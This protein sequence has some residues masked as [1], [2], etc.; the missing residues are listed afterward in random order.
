MVCAVRCASDTARAATSVDFAAW[1]AIS[2][3]EAASSSTELAA[4]VTFCEAALTRL[5]GGARFR[6]HRVGGAVERGR[7][8]FQL[9]R[10]AAQIAERLLDRALGTPRW[11]WRRF[12]CAAPSRAR[13]W[14]GPTVRRS[15]SIMLSRNT[16]TVRAMAPISSGRAGGGNFRRRVAAG[17]PLHGAGQAVERAG[18]AAA[19]QPAEAEADQHGRDADA[20]DDG[21]GPLLRG[22]ERRRGGM[23]RILSPRR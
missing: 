19:D 13:I 3:I 18:D 7:G 10:R 4:D 6:R 23:V 22:R 9:L 16:I 1:P 2:P 17:E 5:L 20:G 11:R 14:S 21:P 15:R 12:R 8:H